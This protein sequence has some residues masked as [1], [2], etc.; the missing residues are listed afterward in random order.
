M[1]KG[2]RLYSTELN[3][4]GRRKNSHS[5]YGLKYSSMMVIKKYGYVKCIHCPLTFTNAE[6]LVKHAFKCRVELFTCNICSKIYT[7][8]NELLRHLHRCN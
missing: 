4:L 2:R 1:P 8:K 5:S 7:D 3:I 6:K